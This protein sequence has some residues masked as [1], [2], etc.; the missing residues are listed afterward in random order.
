MQNTT[1]RI[2]PKDITAEAIASFS[3][4]HSPRTRELMQS[5]VRHLHEFAV[6][7]RLTQEEW[8]AGIRA[9]TGRHPRLGT[10]P[11]ARRPDR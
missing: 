9:L 11:G 6:E 3:G 1:G 5:L 4:A 8:Q 10:R 2:A 7:I